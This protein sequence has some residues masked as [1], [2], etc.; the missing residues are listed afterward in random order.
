MPNLSNIP[1]NSGKNPTGYKTLYVTPIENVTAIPAATDYVVGT[2]FT[3]TAGSI[4]S[5]IQFDTEGGAFLTI[6]TPDANG[7]TGYN[8]TLT[9]FVAGNTAAQK[10]AIDGMDGVYLAIIG[11]TKDNKNEILFEVGRGMRLMPAKEDAA[12]AGGRRGYALVGNMDF[13]GLPLEYTGAIVTTV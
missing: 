10:A 13:N 3:L 6:A 2:D 1:R 12:R 5:E 4:F 11:V 9:A 7:T 8:Y